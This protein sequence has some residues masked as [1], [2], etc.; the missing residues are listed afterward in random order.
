MSDTTLNIL[1]NSINIF[2]NQLNIL[3]TS[4]INI[5]E[6]RIIPPPT[7]KFE[8]KYHMYG[9]HIGTLKLYWQ[10]GENPST[11]SL[12]ELT[13]LNG[14]D[15]TTTLQLDGSPS[16]NAWYKAVAYL[17]EYHKNT[18]RIV[19]LYRKNLGGHNGDMA[20]DGFKITIDDTE[21]GDLDVTTNTTSEWV[22]QKIPT[23]GTIAISVNH[24]EA[25][26]HTAG[27]GISGD[28]VD[29][30]TSNLSETRTS[31]WILGTG[32]T[33]SGSTGPSSGEN[34]GDDYYIFV[35]TTNSSGPGTSGGTTM[36]QAGNY[37][38]LTT[39]NNIQL[40]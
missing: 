18:G 10:D 33:P 29:L 12:N 39:K 31:Y 25:G 22:G 19:F 38:F 3:T 21:L 24:W 16:S 23:S 35:E 27:G 1:S 26:H 7:I 8:F 37:I 17:T 2:D 30:S 14:D 6:T 36:N 34:G 20:L 11:G 28:L 15:E 9:T 32:P 5:A 13:I 40:I 4:L